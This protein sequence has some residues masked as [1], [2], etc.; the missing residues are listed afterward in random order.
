MFRVERTA[1]AATTKRSSP[2]SLM[3]CCRLATLLRQLLSFADF[4]VLLLQR[5][6]KRPPHD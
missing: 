5:E 3:R 1:D 6:P 4:R 2:M